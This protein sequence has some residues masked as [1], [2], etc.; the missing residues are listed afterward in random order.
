MEAN[1]VSYLNS[2]QGFLGVKYDEKVWKGQS[3]GIARLHSIP[4]HSKMNNWYSGVK[5]AL[6]QTDSYYACE[7]DNS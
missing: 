3:Y 6:I 5:Q 7:K 4:C 2:L 1:G